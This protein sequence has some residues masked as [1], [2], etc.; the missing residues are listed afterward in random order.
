MDRGNEYYHLEANK[1]KNRIYFSMTGSIPNVDVIP[2]F[3][4]DWKDMVAEVQQGFTI[5]GDLSKLNPLPKDVDKL[6]EET[7]AW[8]MQNGCGKVA[9]LVGDIGVMAQV[10][11]F[12]ERSGMRSILRAFNFHKTAEIWLDMED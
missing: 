7:Q 9:Q 11:D 3:L 4:Q 1:E 10:N 5:L 2:D 12:A 6:N 8:L